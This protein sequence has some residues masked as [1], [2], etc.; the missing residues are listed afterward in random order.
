MYIFVEEKI[1]ESIENGEFDNLPG[2]GKPLDLKDEFSGMPQDLKQ[3]YRI[4]KN[5][6]YITEEV[7]NKRDS[8]SQDDLLTS[9]TD[10]NVSRDQH[11]RKQFDTFIE[12]RKLHTNSRFAAYAKKIYRKLF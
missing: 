4:L 6:G 10:G 3:A 7:E 2:K 1:K 12:E 11:K 8:I 5:A 9:A